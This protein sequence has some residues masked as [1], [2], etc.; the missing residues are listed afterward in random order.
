MENGVKIYPRGEEVR[1]IADLQLVVDMRYPFMAFPSRKYNV[2]YFK[3]EMKWKLGASQYDESIKKYAKM[4]ENVQNPD[5]TFNSN[6]GQFWFG[7]QSGLWS[8]VT[9]LIRDQ[10]SRRAMIPMLAARHMEPW[11]K[12]TVCTEGVGFR[13][14]N[15][16]L[17]CSVHMRSSDS[18]FGLG[19]DIATFT[20][21]Y[22]LVRAQVSNGIGGDL[23]M[24]L[25][26]ITAMSSHIYSRHYEMVGKMLAEGPQSFDPS[27]T[28]PMCY[29]AGEALRIV[30]MRGKA[31]AFIPE[32]HAL[33][34]WIHK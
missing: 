8:V 28:M 29:S 30:A 31:P 22:H 5:G 3:E 24:G 26:T 14:R 15:G 17:N 20:F 27:V 25:M 7:A 18:V 11:V 34:T 2:A 9:E 21:L 1:E 10:D 6:Y 16:E 4:W 12:D 19:T 32:H 13:I 23:N 33:H